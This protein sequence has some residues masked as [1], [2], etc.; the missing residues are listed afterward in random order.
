MEDLMSR[1]YQKMTRENKNMLVN[2]IAQVDN[3][4]LTDVTEDY[5]FK[6]IKRIRIEELA[7]KCEE[8]ILKGYLSDNGHFYRTNRDDQI[9]MIGQKDLL[10][11][12]PSIT[13]VQWKTED[14]GYITHI[15]ED[16]LKYVYYFG[17]KHKSSLLFKYNHLKELVLKAQDD[18]QVLEVHWNMDIAN[19]DFT[20][21]PQDM[22]TGEA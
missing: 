10:D 19:P 13:V 18:T 9:N 15:K 16:W 1:G 22:E 7:L 2:Y 5:V 17:L 12:D 20:P 14:V 3:I 11:S 4:L 6:M 8:E 21:N